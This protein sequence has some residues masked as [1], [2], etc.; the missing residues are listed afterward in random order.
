MKNIAILFARLSRYGVEQ[1]PAQ[2]N[3][4]E[5]E[6][7]LQCLLGDE[8]EVEGPPAVPVATESTDG[9]EEMKDGSRR[10][11]LKD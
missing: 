10:Q 9:H 2:V 1:L 11:A 4:D 6:T 8:M 3:P 7:Q 5:L